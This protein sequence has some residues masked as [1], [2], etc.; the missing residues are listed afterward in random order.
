MGSWEQRVGR[1]AIVCRWRLA[2]DLDLGL[3]AGV[4][5][6]LVPA[7]EPAGNVGQGFILGFC[8]S[9]KLLFNYCLATS[10]SQFLAP[11]R[12]WLLRSS[13]TYKGLPIHEPLHR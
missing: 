3:G 4:G 11:T 6:P 7:G 13:E 10:L 1:G 9:F 2:L 12:R 8:V 5:I